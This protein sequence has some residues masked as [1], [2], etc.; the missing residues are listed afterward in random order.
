MVLYFAVFL[1]GNPKETYQ[2][3]LDKDIQSEKEHSTFPYEKEKNKHTDS[4][5]N[6]SAK[7]KIRVLKG[8]RRAKEDISF[9]VSSEKTLK[10]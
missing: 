1:E 4:E 6:V 10:K 3:A 7:R 8:Q 9:L 5:K 2:A